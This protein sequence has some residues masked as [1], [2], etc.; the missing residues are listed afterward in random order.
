MLEEESKEVSEKFENS[1]A[2]PYF[3]LVMVAILW[4]IIG[5]IWNQIGKKEKVHHY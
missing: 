4:T 1:R 5:M 3:S 2:I